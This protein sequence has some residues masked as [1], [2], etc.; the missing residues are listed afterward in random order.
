[1]TSRQRTCLLFIQDHIARTGRAPTYAAIATALGDVARANAFA[2]VH[3]LIAS[4]HLT[5]DR[6]GLSASIRV[7][8]PIEPIVDI[9]VFND[10]TKR[11]ERYVVRNR[12]VA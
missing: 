7:I 1:M 5:I 8:R 11:L 3:R 2:L 10:A 4:G 6:G 9:F 12:R